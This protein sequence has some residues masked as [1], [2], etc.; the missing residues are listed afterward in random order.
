[1]YTFGL[2]HWL[3]AAVWSRQEEFDVLV[4]GSWLVV[5]ASLVVYLSWWI[6]TKKK[7]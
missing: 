7:C 1:M 3:A 2:G 5:L 6:Y 4:I